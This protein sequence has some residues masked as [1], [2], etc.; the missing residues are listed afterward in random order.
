M[1]VEMNICS[2]GRVRSEVLGSL[3]LGLNTY[4]SL[5]RFID[6]L[7]GPTF[8][9]SIHRCALRPASPHLLNPTRKVWF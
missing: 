6:A 9:F 8:M 1:A 2:E 3:L 4:F 5:L 7:M